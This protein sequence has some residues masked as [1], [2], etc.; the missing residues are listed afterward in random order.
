MTTLKNVPASVL[1]REIRSRQQ[2]VG[3]LSKR[4]AKLLTK[5]ADL[6]TQIREAGGTVTMTGAVGVRKRPSNDA[7]LRQSLVKL[8]KGKTL[9]V[10][11][12]AIEVQKAGYRT[13][14]ENF[15]TIVNQCLIIN[16]DLFK[17]VKRGHYTAK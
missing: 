7:N 10:T 8:L 15:R 12:A 16:S 4:R 1:H 5:L 6:D 9:T 14:A 13:S 11:E 2:Q 3:R 17:K